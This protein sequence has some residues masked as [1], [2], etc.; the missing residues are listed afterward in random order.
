MFVLIYVRGKVSCIGLVL[1]SNLTRSAHHAAAS[2]SSGWTSCPAQWL[3]YLSLGS[4]FNVRQT[5]VLLTPKE[6][7]RYPL[8]QLREKRMMSSGCAVCG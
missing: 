4:N 7:A 8:I 3:S 2:M 5:S 6:N 1:V